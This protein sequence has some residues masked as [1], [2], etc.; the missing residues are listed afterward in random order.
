MKKTAALGVVLVLTMATGLRAQ[1]TKPTTDPDPAEATEPV[2][3]DTPKAEPKAEPVPEPVVDPDPVQGVRYRVELKSGSVIEGVV[4]AK[5]VFERRARIGGYVSADDTD[6]GCGVRLWFPAKQN[7]FIFMPL[8]YVARMDELGSLSV[9]EGK[10]IAR[11]QIAAKSRADTERSQIRA[12]RIVT[13]QAASEAAAD[14]AAAT[15]EAEAIAS[16]KPRA[17]PLNEQESAQAAHLASLLI[18]YPPTRWSPDTPAEIERRK[19]VLGLF[20]SEEEKAFLASFDDWLQAYNAWRESND[21]DVV[22]ETRPTRPDRP[23]KRSPRP[24]PTVKRP[25]TPTW[26]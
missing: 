1:D 4:L 18:T 12:M 11:A 26:K 2:K 8:A 5:G 17:A 6:P 16:V 25:K 7:G 23:K 9:D 10:K 20:P 22:V 19:V 15:G 24:R 3:D 13:E 14:E 21:E